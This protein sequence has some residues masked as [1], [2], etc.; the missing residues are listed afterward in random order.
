[1]RIRSIDAVCYIF[2]LAYCKIARGKRLYEL[3]NIKKMD[4]ENQ[5]GTV[6]PI[7]VARSAI[8][9]PAKSVFAVPAGFLEDD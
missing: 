2:S 9:L 1:V 6:Q 4:R 5:G 8:L 7:T 3:A